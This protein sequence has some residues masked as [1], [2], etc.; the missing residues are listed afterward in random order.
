VFIAHTNHGRVIAHTR[1]NVKEITRMALD[2]GSRGTDRAAAKPRRRRYESETI[3][4]LSLQEARIEADARRQ[5]RPPRPVPQLEETTRRL[6]LQ[7]ARVAAEERRRARQT[8]PVLTVDPRATER[9]AIERT[10]R[11]LTRR[12]EALYPG[13][14]RGTYAGGLARILAAG[15]SMLALGHPDPATGIRELRDY[16]RQA[17]AIIMDPTSS[18]RE[19]LEAAGGTYAV[20]GLPGIFRRR[21]KPVKPRAEKGGLPPVP[22]GHVR[23]YRGE[24][25]TA[26]IDPDDLDF[27][28]G[29]KGRWWTDTPAVA[30]E[31]ARRHKGRV[32]YL[33]IPKEQA[34]PWSR[35][36]EDDSGRTWTEYR[37][38]QR[39]DISRK[40]PLPEPPVPGAEKVVGSLGEAKRLRL[41]QEKL[42]RQERGKR[43]G[44]FEEAAEE[45][46]GQAGYQAAL[47]E[48]KGELPK[49]RFGA[50]ENEMDQ[51]TV[52]KLFSH[53][54]RREDLRP[55]EKLNAQRALGNALEGRVPTRADI[56][57]LGQVFGPDT[58][59]QIQQSVGFWAKAKNVGLNLI[60]VPRSIKASFDLSAPFR[61]GLVLGARHPRMF[62]RE[63]RP[64]IKA[65]RSEGA[66]RDVMDDIAS[67]PTFDAM[68]KSRLA[69]TDLE[70]LTMREEQ[71]MSNYAEHIPVVGR[72]VRASGRAYVA[73]LNKFRADAF[74]N[75]LQVAEAQGRDIT[76]PV[77]LKSIATWVNHA[78]GRGSV[79]GLEGAMVP[80]NA[81]LFSPR[82]IAS[83][84]N[85][86]FNPGYY[87]RLDPF[88]RRQALQGMAQ[89]AGAVSLTL[90][91]AKMSGADVGLDPR[92]SDF[93]KIKVGDTRVDVAG[94]FQQYLVVAS[95]LAKGEMVSSTTGELVTLEGGFAKP[96]RADILQRFAEGKLAPVPALANVLAK[97]ETF[98]GEEP[99]PAREAGRLFVP[100]GWE[101]TYDTARAEGTGPAAATAVLGSI[102]FGVQTYGLKPPRA[103]TKDYEE[104]LKTISAAERRG[105]IDTAT[106]E[107]LRVSARTRYEQE[108]RARQLKGK[109]EA[110]RDRQLMID[111]A[112]RLNL[113]LAELNAILTQQGMTSATTDDLADAE[114]ALLELHA[115]GR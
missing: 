75:Y 67:R 32:Y 84:V 93:G 13:P 86:L 103:A 43:G 46:G 47:V 39:V 63:F 51:A 106:A 94:G 38:G 61:Q 105:Q 19:K 35:L 101:A 56:R 110:E 7:E 17:Q 97:N 59:A 20:A 30:E 73:F 52:D 83:R 72:G 60:N 11:A 26:P 45:V 79:K 82:L 2:K 107:Q 90:W 10:T 64:M 89:L 28:G 33:D 8:A 68:T 36:R 31:Y 113:P 115:V 22:P 66:Y 96:S 71:F 112:V 29:S 25:E 88:V 98:E 16:A 76:D 44:R 23:L 92:S 1:L 69:L 6:S 55:Y 18:R 77:L 53:V 62:A 54:Q 102:G 40:L 91:M 80:L 9:A 37:F 65:F 57:I 85:L 48:L 21:G 12:K 108:I 50:L 24:G 111:D 27:Y 49:L 58:A 114:L 87:A 109:P 5:A 15:P 99:D 74:D 42:Y 4:R 95:R 81:L 104:Q 3:Q 100:L 34:R 70:S 14:P 78:T 41:E